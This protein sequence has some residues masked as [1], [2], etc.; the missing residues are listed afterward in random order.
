MKLSLNDVKEHLDDALIKY[1][2]PGFIGSDPIQIPHSFTRK[3]DIEIAGL[4]AATLAWGQRK[5]IINKCNELM[6]MMD[7]APYDFVVGHSEEEL[8]RL[9]SFKHRTFNNEDLRYFI[10]FLNF[11]YSQND[12]LEELFYVSPDKSTHPVKEGLINYH[13]T[14]FSLQDAPS[15]TKK[16][17]STPERKSACKR[18]NMYLRWMVRSDRE[19][20]DFGIWN[21]I[22]TADLICP[23]DVHV[24]RIAKALNLL[25][26]KQSDWLAAEELTSNLKKMNPEDPV[27]YDLALFGLGVM[28][29]I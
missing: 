28:E 25:K 15:R 23:L 24:E 10:R 12:S 13:Q 6:D 27:K 18:L 21:K 29:G 19:G 8:Q 4:F 26:R 7:R 14:F 16:H 20:I 22:S 3:Q 9:S 5:T 2:Q 11:W 17:V 1:A